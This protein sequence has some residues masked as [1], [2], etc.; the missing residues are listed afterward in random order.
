MRYSLIKPND[1]ANGMGVSVSLWTQGCPHYCN[2]CFNKETWDFNGGKEFGQD[3]LK[4]ILD[5]INADGIKRNL[6]ILGGEP[7]CE[8]NIEGVLSLIESV[9]V[10]YPLIKVY[11]WTG[12]TFEDLII[13]YPNMKFDS[14][15][16]LIDGKFKKE[17][18]DLS[19]T[20]RGSKNQRVI[21]VSKTLKTDTVVTLY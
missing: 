12:Y 14:I 4:Y 5:I 6:S 16:I 9:K 8:Q 11:V 19:L 7:L 3:E 17:L 10:K 2:G 18:K 1:V 21:D 13:K 15:D 20:L